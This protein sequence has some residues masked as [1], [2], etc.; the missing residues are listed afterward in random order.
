M[1]VLVRWAA[2]TLIAALLLPAEQARAV[3]GEC[4]NPEYRARFDEALRRIDYDCIERFRVEVATESGPR[5][6]RIIHDRDADWLVS[7]SEMAEFDRGAAA[8]AAAL[9]A[10]GARELEDVT[11][12]LADDLP[13]RD[14]AGRFSDIA[15][16]TDTQ[17]DGECHIIV[18]LAGP[19]SYRRY[20]AWVIGHEIFHCVQTANLSE[21]QINSGSVGAGGGGDWWIEGSASWFAALALPDPGPMRQFVAGFN[22]ASDSTALNRLAYEAVVFFLWLGADEPNRVMTFLNRMAHSREESAQR[23]AMV[24]ALPQAEWLRFASAYLDSDIRH[25]HGADLGLEPSEGAVWQWSET[26]TEEMSL[27]PFV[28]RRGVVAFECGRWRTTVAPGDLHHARPEEGGAWAPLPRSIET[29][30]GTGGSY[31]FAAFNAGMSATPL[32]VV[33]EMEAGCGGCADIVQTDSCLFGTWQ[34]TSG[35]A[36][37][38]MRRQGAPV[39]FTTNNESITLRADGTF[40]T[41]A[42]SGA[43]AGRMPDGTRVSGENQARAGGRWS[44]RGGMLNLCPD[45]QQARG[46]GAARLPDRQRMDVPM[47][48][49]GP[50]M[51]QMRYSCGDGAMSTEVSIPGAP[52]MTSGYTRSER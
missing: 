25:P 11:I 13:P 30:S 7:S 29:M 10:I 31:R 33:G 2:L 51:T 23:A 27:E 17:N 39:Q 38:W 28:L 8:A 19:G 3:F 16:W 47:I 14:G 44:A 34:L 20:A 49:G 9:A 50:T 15:A 46:S 12:L 4:S 41:G 52:P 21:A 1:R 45:L 40:L 6:I 36:A 26:R 24:E 32:S 18:Y 42:F 48:A 22:A 35:G 5:T 43:F 37:E